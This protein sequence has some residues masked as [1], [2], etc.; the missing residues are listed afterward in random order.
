MSQ[1][2]VLFL[3]SFL[4]L[5]M[6]ASTLVAVAPPEL[7]RFSHSETCSGKRIPRSFHRYVRLVSSRDREGHLIR[8][9]SSVTA[10]F[11]PS[12]LRVSKHAWALL[13]SMA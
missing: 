6:G 1:V 10:N 4:Q 11:C 5:H 13:L 2:G 7:G 8:V 12:G 3:A 9:Q